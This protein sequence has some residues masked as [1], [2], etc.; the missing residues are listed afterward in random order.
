MS[1]YGMI[2]WLFEKNQCLLNIV[3]LTHETMRIDIEEYPL[4]KTG[5]I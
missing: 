4:L 2:F 5:P 1:G 3:H